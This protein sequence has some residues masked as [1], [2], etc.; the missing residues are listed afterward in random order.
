[1][2]VS[3]AA[4]GCKSRYTLEARKK[5]ITFHRFPRSNPA[6][7][8]KWRVAMKR[9]TSTGEL[10]MPSRYQRLCSLHFKQ[11][12]FDTTGQT[13]RLRDDVIPSIFSF[14]DDM[15]TEM[16]ENKSEEN[17]VPVTMRIPTVPEP[18][19]EAPKVEPVPPNQESSI[20]CVQLQDHLYFV[21][22]VET[23][24][25]KLQ[26]SEESRVQKEK[27]LRNAKDR[28]KRLRQ[29]C[30]SIYKELRKRKLISPQLQ[31]K[32]QLYGDIPIELFKKPESEYSAQQ[33]L[34]CLTL[35]LHDPMSYKYLRNAF[36]L[37]LPGPRKL[38]QWLKIDTD[39][40]GFNT[41]VL[42][43]LMKKK[44]ECPDLYTRASL[45]VG[46][47]SIQQHVTFDSQQNELVGF[48]NLGKRVD[49][50]GSQEVANETL[51]FFLVGAVGNWEALVAY[52]FVK[53]LTAEA[54]K[55]LLLHVL[56]ELCEHNLE[57]ISVTMERHLRNQEMCSLLGCEFLDPRKLKTHFS[58]ANSENKH[59]IIF[60]VHHEQNLVC[61]MLEKCGTIQSPSGLIL[62]KHI[63]DIFNF[64]KSEMQNNGVNLFPMEVIT[65]LKKV[66]L[67][68]NKLSS[69]IADTLSKLQEL[70]CERF[71]DSSATITFIKVM[72]QL[73][74]I[75]CNSSPCV[76]MDK[77][78]IFHANLQETLHAL[79]NIEEYL[80]S[81]T[82][83]DNCPLCQS[84]RSWYIL[85]FLVNIHSFTAL[86]PHVLQEQDCILTQR[87][88][89]NHLKIFFNHVRNAD[90]G[91]IENPTALHVK[92]AVQH[93]MHQCGLLNINLNNHPRKQEISFVQVSGDQAL[94]VQDLCSPF[95]E[96]AIK[97]PDHVYSSRVLDSLLSNPHMYIAGWVVR[98]A[99]SQ[100][101]CTKC[102]C[103]LVSADTQDFSEVSHLLKH[104]GGEAY[105]VPS[106]G[107]TKTIQMAKKQLHENLRN[108]Q[109]NPRTSCLLLQ[110]QVLSSLG[111]IDIFNLREHI[112]ETK[113]GINNHHFRLLR[114]VTSLYH[115]LCQPYIAKL[116]QRNE[117][118]AHVKQILTQ[119]SC[120]Q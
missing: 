95:L 73:F 112:I 25:R 34:F 111:S 6:L 109:Y 100:L 31:E 115:A 67:I 28:E 66:K 91:F 88:S 105:F 13:K 17:H 94:F 43:A 102:R 93:L 84:S 4:S 60:D 63:Y 15:Q 97:Q 12:C 77:G 61:D 9:A 46:T 44:Q 23:L 108:D 89:T 33:R 87:F 90:D 76:K 24:K 1:M 98:Q 40:P 8:D 41:Q 80:I 116:I 48:V 16:L 27:E 117:Y 96:N 42:G 92:Q 113:L 110:H 101:A 51:M 119:P 99:F 103:A 32:L 75:L 30:P 29:I 107:T 45:V 57:I 22:D 65:Q 69:T 120:A 74:N 19:T 58:L 85:G 14:P 36:K 11:T 38:R 39:K 54:Q 71:V 53:S 79:Q 82:T 62:W 104:K 47:M 106:E 2:P 72:H 18:E 26:A 20:N 37:P 35:Q 56:H 3:C 118:R 86:L 59:Y 78:P 68:V 64:Q 5:G 50:S 70:Q 10:W 81:L 49:S 21:P 55:Q 7:L 114:L 52:F 83:N